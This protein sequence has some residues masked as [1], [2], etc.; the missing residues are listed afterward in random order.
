MLVSCWTIW[1]ELILGGAVGCGLKPPAEGCGV[2]GNTFDGPVGSMLACTG[3]GEDV[4]G[5][6]RVA[7]PALA[8]AELESPPGALDPGAA[9]AAEASCGAGVGSGS[10][11]GTGIATGATYRGGLCPSEAL[12]TPVG[13]LLPLSCE[14]TLKVSIRIAFGSE[15]EL[16]RM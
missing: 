5:G 11:A 10:A 3:A 8:E 16:C 9:E 15:D 4:G 13:A 14:R 2:C 7:G 12:S 1:S 6:S